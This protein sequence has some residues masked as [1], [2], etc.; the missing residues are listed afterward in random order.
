MFFAYL[1]LRLWGF[2]V[3]ARWP[4]WFFLRVKK[5]FICRRL[6]LCWWLRSCTGAKEDNDVMEDDHLTNTESLMMYL[7]N[8]LQNELADNVLYY[9]A[10]FIVKS[11]LQKTGMWQLQG[12]TFTL[13]KW[14]R[15]CSNSQLPSLCQIDLFQTKKPVAFPSVAVLKIVKATESIFRQRVIEEQKGINYEKN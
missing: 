15:R 3:Q 1:P 14:C 7:D 13:W 10:G 4:D 11:L 6:L 12:W 9:I 2:P 5:H 8:E